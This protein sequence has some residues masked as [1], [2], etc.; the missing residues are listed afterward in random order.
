M[1]ASSTIPVSADLLISLFHV[2]DYGVGF[3]ACNT[4]LDR[5]QQEVFE[6]YGKDVLTLRDPITQYDR[7]PADVQQ[8]C[9]LLGTDSEKQLKPMLRQPPTHT[10][11]VNDF[12]WLVDAVNEAITRYRER[13]SYFMLEHEYQTDLVRELGETGAEVFTSIMHD[14][15]NEHLVCGNADRSIRELHQWLTSIGAPYTQPPPPYRE[16]HDIRFAD[17]HNRLSSFFEKKNA[18]TTGSCDNGSAQ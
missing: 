17:M 13:T 7:A 10:V 8:I 11:V 6:S 5:R 14:T 9:T 15:L 2:I 1:H 4:E 18:D 16:K 12:R 3:N